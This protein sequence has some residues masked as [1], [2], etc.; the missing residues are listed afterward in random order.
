MSRSC[1][2]L[3]LWN[4]I[5][6]YLYLKENKINTQK[7][8]S[9]N[10]IFKMRI[11]KIAFFWECFTRWR[12]QIWQNQ[13]YMIT[14]YFFFLLSTKEKHIF[15][16]PQSSQERPPGIMWLVMT[17]G[18]WVK[19]MLA[20]SSP[21][22]QSSSPKVSLPLDF[23]VKSLDFPIFSSFLTTLEAASQGY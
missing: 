22:S 13:C 12:W 19:R 18:T 11:W 21:G 17:H 16:P 1:S 2:P 8:H 3:C 5:N 20:T 10:Q 15:Q 14:D 6:V 23:P 7:I 9:T 4:S